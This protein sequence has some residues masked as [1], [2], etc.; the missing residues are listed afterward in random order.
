M[1]QQQKVTDRLNGKA[2]DFKSD[3]TAA[4]TDLTESAIQ[5]KDRVQEASSHAVEQT[6]DF[7][8]KY[9]MYTAIGAAAVGFL[10]GALMRRS[11]H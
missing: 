11:K 5:L 2:Q 9:P 4:I 3:A 6:V 1:Q 10:A 8:K 7:V